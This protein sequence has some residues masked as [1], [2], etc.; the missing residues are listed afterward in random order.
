MSRAVLLLAVLLAGCGPA[1]AV[2]VDPQPAPPRAVVAPPPPAATGL[3][4]EIRY[5]GR[6]GG[7]FAAA[8]AQRPGPG[9]GRVVR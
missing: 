9:D 5:P 8:A 6:G 7:R 3:P 4:K 1:A 2:P